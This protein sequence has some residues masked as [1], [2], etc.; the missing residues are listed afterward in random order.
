MSCRFALSFSRFRAMFARSIAAA[1]LAAPALSLLGLPAAAEAGHPLSVYGTVDP[2]DP[3]YLDIN[4]QLFPGGGSAPDRI[5]AYTRQLPTAE[6]LLA[7]QLRPFAV[8]Y[9]LTGGYRPIYT[10]AEQPIGDQTIYTHG[11][12]GYVYRPVYEAAAY[13]VGYGGYT[14]TGSSG[15][16]Y[17]VENPGTPYES[18]YGSSQGRAAVVDVMPHYGAGRPQGYVAAYGGGYYGG[19]DYGDA[20]FQAPLFYG[21]QRATRQVETFAAPAA[22]PPIGQPTVAPPVVQQQP[23][24]APGQGPRPKSLEELPNPPRGE[25]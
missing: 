19:E 5:P 17:V 20:D 21:V 14:T 12:N 1:A 3:F 22:H 9:S 15:R 25:F 7:P 23:R 2:N 24:L 4:D 10:G 18:S 13:P 6:S 11:G 8:G 16:A